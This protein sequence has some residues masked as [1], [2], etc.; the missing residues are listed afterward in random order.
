M[1]PLSTM[2]MKARV[3]V[4]REI[5]WAL[6]ECPFSE[7]VNIA[8]AGNGLCAP[9]LFKSRKVRPVAKVKKSSI[10][11]AQNSPKEFFLALLERAAIEELCDKVNGIFEEDLTIDCENTDLAQVH[12]FD[13]IMWIAITLRIGLHTEASPGQ[14]I[15][16]TL[17][18]EN[19]LEKLSG[20]FQNTLLCLR[21]RGE[22]EHWETLHALR[23][24]ISRRFQET[25]TPGQ[26]LL[27]K[28]FSLLV[29]GQVCPLNMAV[30]F[31]VST[32]YVCNFYLYSMPL[33]QKGSEASVLE[34]LLHHLLKP[35]VNK[36]YH[37]QLDSSVFM[38]G[39]LAEI[40]SGLGF[41]LKFVNFGLN[42][43]TSENECSAFVEQTSNLL[44]SHLQGWLGPAVLSSLAF[45][46]LLFQGFWLIVHLTTINSYV[47]HSMPA[48]K[49]ERQMNLREFVKVL[50]SQLPME[51]FLAS[52]ETSDARNSSDWSHNSNARTWSSNSG[53]YPDLSSSSGV[54]KARHQPGLC[55]LMNSGNSCYMNAV[56]QC[57]CSTVPLVEHFL[58]E[59]TKEDITRRCCE[60]AEAFITLLETVWLGQKDI[61]SPS[62]V[63]GKL[64][65]HH[66]LFSNNSQQD[67][68][69]FLLFLFNALHDDLVRKGSTVEK[70]VSKRSQS[71]KALPNSA[72]DSSI[73]TDLFEGQLNYVT[74]CLHCD[75]QTLSNQIFTILSLPIPPD[76]YKCPLEDCL[77]LFF[78][79]STLTKGDQMWCP[80]C[81]VRRDTAVLTAL[82]KPPEIL[83][84]HLKRFECQGQT[85]KK[86]RTN[87]IFP[88]NNL[89]LTP[90]LS[91]ASSQHS[92][93]SLYGVVN[94]TGDLDM[95]H[96]TAC[97]RSTMTRRWHVF[98]DATVESVHDFVVQSPNA[99]ILLYSREQYSRP[100]VPGVRLYT[101]Q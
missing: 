31:E 51:Y 63:R 87:V 41:H 43:Q 21:R 36:G 100:R 35:Y 18:I 17:S 20:S 65:G 77:A 5:P 97:C 33:L 37:V 74:L 39:K 64:C 53:R 2:S 13:F 4:V 94:H 24:H 75:N 12:Y 25:Y 90:Y 54:T 70:K 61:W 71:K 80:Q 69:E 1:V 56:L 83:I 68:Q 48:M 73:I 78:Q 3:M 10:C 57:L 62:K 89:D 40:F 23:K 82:S 26:Q 15:R 7:P 32:G 46:D 30:L 27:V 16:I 92:S 6:E 58:N 49:T 47:M 22:D 42:D 98:D 99:Y 84:L 29:D 86:L 93:Y 11:L 101:T 81:A 88:L 14:P 34:Q 66:S 96:Y 52:P 45:R 44:Q 28:K 76:S 72:T 95:G 55:G 91:S 19:W 59:Q 50:A 79:Q 38:E 9:G 8:S 60:V 85:K 67:A